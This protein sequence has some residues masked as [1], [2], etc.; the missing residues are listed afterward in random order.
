MCQ[1]PAAP[2]CYTSVT[3]H[4]DSQEALKSAAQRQA[5]ESPAS[6]VSIAVVSTHGVGAL[7]ATLHHLRETI[8]YGVEVIVL[9]A[10]H[11]E[12][13]V[14]YITRHYLRG[15]VSAI[16]LEAGGAE[17]E[18]AHCGLDTAFQIS[19]GE[20]L[21]RVQDDLAFA[22]GW[23]D[24]VTAALRANPDIGMLGLVATDEPRRRGRPPRVRP[25]EEID[26]VDLRAFAITQF[27]LREHLSELKGER[28]AEGCR[29][30]QRLREL[31]YRIA[32]LPGQLATGERPIA[33][34]SGAEL[35]ADLAFH[36]GEREA[37]AGLRQSYQLGDEVLTPCAVCDEEE[38]EV[39]G[40]QIDFCETHGVALGYTYTMRCSGCHTVSV[41][42]DHQFRCQA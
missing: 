14:S 29:F 7:R 26:Q 37:M 24:A 27:A 34:E 5:A 10:Q 8:D 1:S 41:E 6:L 21:V 39:L 38:L 40:A 18:M 30:Q 35:E 20:I 11:R 22:P 17:R 36:P 19:S 13:V 23:L 4:K 28:C 25:P 12:D 9:A 31:G 33:L 2:A 42:E 16:A 15:D 32:Y 3:L